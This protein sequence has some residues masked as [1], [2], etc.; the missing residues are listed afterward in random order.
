LN[1][2]FSRD[3][4][5]APK[6]SRSSSE[7]WMAFA[8]KI[9]VDSPKEYDFIRK[10]VLQDWGSDAES[11]TVSMEHQLAWALAVVPGWADPRKL[12]R[13]RRRGGVNQVLLAFLMGTRD[14]S[15]SLFALRY[16]SKTLLPVKQKRIIAVIVIFFE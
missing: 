8:L 16:F 10:T 12:S 9:A 5:D 3:Y 15:S 6:E 13:H 4:L 7:L 1:R 11:G 14:E 2:A